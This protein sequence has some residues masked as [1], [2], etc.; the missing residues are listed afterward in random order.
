MKKDVFGSELISY[1]ELIFHHLQCPPC[2]Y[3]CS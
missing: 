1:F 3:F 2:W